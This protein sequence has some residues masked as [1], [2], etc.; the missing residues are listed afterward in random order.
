MLGKVHSCKHVALSLFWEIQIFIGVSDVW[1]A[2][3]LELEGSM[4]AAC[5]LMGFNVDA[6]PVH[7]G[8]S[9]HGTHILSGLYWEDVACP[10][11]DQK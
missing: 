9:C 8:V 7:L 6:S 5:R 10:Q 4:Q 11:S 3:V 2:P 1:E